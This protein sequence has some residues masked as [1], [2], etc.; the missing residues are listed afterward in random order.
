VK[1]DSTIFH[2]KSVLFNEAAAKPIKE[3]PLR[4][5]IPIARWAGAFLSIHQTTPPES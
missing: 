4:R 2:K 1:N 3:A 5:L